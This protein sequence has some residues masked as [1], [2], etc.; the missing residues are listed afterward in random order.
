MRSFK[1]V[2][3]ITAALMGSASFG[4]AA[5][6]IPAPETVELPPEVSAVAVN[7]WYIRGD[8]GYSSYDHDDFRFFQGPS[9]TG[10]IPDP[11][12]DS[13]F[14]LSGGIGY[15]VNDYFRVDATYSRF[16]GADVTGSSRGVS[17]APGPLQCNF[18]ALGTLCDFNDE[19][20]FDADLLMANAYVDLGNFSG[21]TPYVGAGIGGA[22]VTYG[23][24]TNTQNCS[25]PSDPGC[26]PGVDGLVINHNG[27]DEWRFAW[28]LHAG[29][30]I[31]LT[32]QLKADVGYTYTQIEGQ[33]KAFGFP[34]GDV[35][36]GTQGFDGG[37]D[38]HT[39]RV[40]LR[41]AFDNSACGGG[42]PVGPEPVFK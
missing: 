28:Q 42:L 40:G 26:F 27:E 4:Q 30:S 3:L 15:Q 31:D 41:Y 10:I 7:G 13:S 6:L 21:F 37:F 34:I 20:E 19:Q 18:A 11:D 33:G 14:F 5:D 12:T 25:D 35:N 39:G 17:S 29:A 24:L 38:A 16:Y 32:C 2:S 1:L 22:H 9:L 23:G 36:I 8:I